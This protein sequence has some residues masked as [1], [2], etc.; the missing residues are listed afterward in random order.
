MTKKSTLDQPTQYPPID[1][2]E[3]DLCR[4]I[5]VAS[6]VQAVID[7]RSTASTPSQKLD[8][9][10]AIRWLKAEAGERSE[11]AEVCELAGLEFE[12]TQKR[13]WSIAMDKDKALDFRCLKK[14]LLENPVGELRS[15][16]FNRLKRQESYR[17]NK[18]AKSRKKKK[19]AA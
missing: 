7:A 8:K 5:W 9:E 19:M 3:T 1:E 12:P 13:L 16:Y 14:A 11:F 2:S 18:A 6:A 10:S 17:E 15:A 4:S